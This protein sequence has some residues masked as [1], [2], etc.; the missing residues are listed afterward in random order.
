LNPEFKPWRTNDWIDEGNH[1]A[2]RALQIR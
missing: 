2:L 1:K